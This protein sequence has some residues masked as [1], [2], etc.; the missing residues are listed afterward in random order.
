[1]NEVNLRRADVSTQDTHT[2]QASKIE[3]NRQLAHA[4]S[5]MDK[6]SSVFSKAV[7]S[8]TNPPVDEDKAMKQ[9]NDLFKEPQK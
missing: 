9:L 4:E 3:Q 8:F 2:T 5:W 6:L 1:M 7:A